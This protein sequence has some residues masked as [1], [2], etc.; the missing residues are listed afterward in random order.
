MAVVE[1][2]TGAQAEAKLAV[3]LAA[4]N[5]AVAE[6]PYVG[7]PPV[8][9]TID[10]I[11]TYYR[12]HQPERVA[13]L[14]RE[15]LRRCD[16]QELRT[17]LSEVRSRFG[18]DIWDHTCCVNMTQFLSYICFRDLILEIHFGRIAQSIWEGF[19]KFIFASC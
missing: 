15:M 19:V 7:S 5:A 16:E 17:W 9:L 13:G 4:T 14:P 11:T 3:L 8:Q 6:L 12:R 18:A 2:L 10:L 1:Q